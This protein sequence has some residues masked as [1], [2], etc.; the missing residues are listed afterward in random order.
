VGTNPACSCWLSGVLAVSLAALPRPA[1]AEGGSPAPS[2]APQ[3]RP[4]PAPYFV[5][6]R[7]GHHSPEYA[8]VAYSFG[9]PGVIAGIVADAE[10][11]YDEV[12]AGAGLNFYT[13]GGN[14]A[15][16]YALGSRATDSWYLELY[17]TPAVTSGPRSRSRS[18]AAP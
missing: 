14:G 5:Y 16:F 6:L 8:F 11:K 18:L 12:L 4:A 3:A 9:R 15:S 1:L 2:A 7:Y 13:P 17:A 10:A